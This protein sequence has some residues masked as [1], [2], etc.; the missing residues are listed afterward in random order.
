M[1]ETG[2]SS[3]DVL[4]DMKTCNDLINILHM[5]NMQSIGVPGNRQ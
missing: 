3:F 5:L 2:Q 1:L 4:Q